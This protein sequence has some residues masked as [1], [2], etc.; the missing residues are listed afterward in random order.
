MY[1]LPWVG[2]GDGRVVDSPTTRHAATRICG[3]GITT[4]SYLKCYF[5]SVDG[6]RNALVGYQ[7]SGRG[8]LPQNG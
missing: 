7:T 2:L 8:G 3:I 5:G 1:E 4:V 6:R